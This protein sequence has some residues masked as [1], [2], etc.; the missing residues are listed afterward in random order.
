MCDGERCDLAADGNQGIKCV[1]ERIRAMHMQEGLRIV[2][3]YKLILIDYNM[4]GMLG[5]EVAIQIR[6]LYALT[7]FK[8]PRMYCFSSD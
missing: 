4:P 1:R 2:E 8:L 5:T 7:E 3:N 6:S